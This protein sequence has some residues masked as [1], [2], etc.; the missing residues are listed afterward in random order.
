MLTEEDIIQME[1][2]LEPQKAGEFEL[3]KHLR[4]QG[5]KIED[6]SNNPSYWSRDID[7]IMDGSTTIE[8]KWDDVISS[9]GNLFIETVSDTEKHKDGWYIFCE[10]DKLYYGD[11]VAEVFYIFDF[12]KLKAHIE[13][14][15]AE[16]KERYAPDFGKDG[17]YKYSKG[18]LVPLESL[19]GLYE[20]ITI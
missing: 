14:H 9:T 2:L 4:A 10:A 3:K 12:W 7:L 11:A 6:V 16:Y 17:I 8:V 1:Y 15:K 18:Y 19:K 20:T 13:A 5:H